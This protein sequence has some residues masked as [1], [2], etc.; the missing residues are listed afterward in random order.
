MAIRR[1]VA[2]H[3]VAMFA[4]SVS[5][6]FAVPGSHGLQILDAISERPE[7][8]GVV[9]RHEQSAAFMADGF[10]RAGGGFG[11][12]VSSTGPGLLNSLTAMATATGDGIPVLNIA[13]CADAR[14]S[15]AHAGLVH[16]VG[17]QLTAAAEV[18]RLALRVREA[19]EVVPTVRLAAQQLAAGATGAVTLEVPRD[20]LAAEITVPARC[21][22]LVAPKTPDEGL[23]RVVELLCRG[24][25]PLM[26]TG[27]RARAAAASVTSLARKLDAPVFSSVLGKGVIDEADPLSLG[28]FDKDNPVHEQLMAMAE[29]LILIGVDLT[30]QD[31]SPRSLPP[32]LDVVSLDVGR[33][34]SESLWPVRET[35][36]GD[37]NDLCQRIGA[38]CADCSTAEKTS[39]RVD[40]VTAARADRKAR[41][42]SVPKAAELMDALRTAL[43]PDAILVNDITAAAYWARE[44]FPV[45]DPTSFLYP[46]RYAPL[47]YALPAAIGA[48]FAAPSRPVVALCGDGGFLFTATELA[49]VRQYD[50]P[51]ICVI[52]DNAGYGLIRDRQL[53][54]HGRHFM[55]D[56]VNPDFAALGRAFG[57]AGTTARDIEELRD[58]LGLAIAGKE[59]HI[60][61]L[62]LDI[63]H[64]TMIPPHHPAA[65]AA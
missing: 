3:I 15:G 65:S 40:A 8:T 38:R 48:H 9:V 45:A 25:R 31:T 17:D 30:H 44:M 11:V 51:V 2:Q 1:S 32:S 4:D 41:V 50:V 47:G 12:C 36:T 5:H 28:V 64:P 43:P 42:N 37:L 6:V 39:A 61:T 24:G 23:S 18:S 7:L 60:L 53:Q 52:I 22:R 49:T 21:S 63:P 34:R 26:W 57:V 55:A 56:L 19:E 62:R 54:Q 10:A 35:L 16:E 59:P 14:L 58:L 27:G 46:W 13:T 33:A 29:P 20:V